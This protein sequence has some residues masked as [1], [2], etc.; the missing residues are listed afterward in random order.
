LPPDSR[1]ADCKGPVGADGEAACV[2]GA[3]LWRAVELE[4]V[5]CDDGACA[6][7]GVAQDAVGEVADK[8]G[9]GGLVGGELVC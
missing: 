4:L 3:G 9:V 6:A 7:R 1:A 2:D 5:V 8:G